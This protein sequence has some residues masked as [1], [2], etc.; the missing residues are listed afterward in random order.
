MTNIAKNSQLCSIPGPGKL[1]MTFFSKFDGSY[2]FTH[3]NLVTQNSI[4]KFL[5]SDTGEEGEDRKRNRKR[6]QKKKKVFSFM[7]L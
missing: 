3:K 5:T 7:N 6:K 1:K 4:A 2:F